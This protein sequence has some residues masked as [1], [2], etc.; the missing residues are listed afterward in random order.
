MKAKAISRTD[1]FWGYA[2]SALNISAGLILLPLIL[3][4]LSSETVALWIVFTTLV[5][6]TQLL[7]LGFQPTIARY[8][9]YIYAGSQKIEKIGVTAIQDDTEGLNRKLLDS[10]VHSARSVYRY[11]S[12]IAGTIMLVGGTA[13]VSSLVTENQSRSECLVAWIIYATGYIIN[14][15]YGYLNGLIQGRGDVTGVNKI[16]I[17]SRFILIL[18]SVIALILGYGLLGLGIASLLSSATGRFLSI[19]LFQQKYEPECS[20]QLSELNELKHDLLKTLWHNAS[21]LGIVNIG[22]FFILKANVLIASS[23]L[24]LGDASSYSITLTLLTTLSGMAMVICQIQIPYVSALQTSQKKEKL[25]RIYGEIQVTSLIVYVIGLML[26]IVL[27][28]DL[29]S[30]LG[31][32]ATLLPNNL[33]LLYGV[34][35]FLEVNHSIAASYIATTNHLPFVLAAIISGLAVTTLSLLT[36]GKFGVMGIILAQGVVQAAYNN[37]K[38]PMMAA[39]DLDE[40][41]ISIYRLGFFRLKKRLYKSVIH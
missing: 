21:R 3:H 35:T 39:K 29:L 9:A 26:L 32:E 40:D 24:G 5:G 37:W 23:I 25:A 8:A 30:A 33:L 2:A 7:E 38:W 28:N 14:F 19:R 41:I 6:L 17:I 10:L 16:T 20:L 27:G 13:Y 11:I 18:A 15:Y 34:I 31:S 12:I 4:F 1:V 22:T 36:V